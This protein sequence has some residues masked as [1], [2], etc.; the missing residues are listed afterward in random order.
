MGADSVI[1]LN[2][3]PL[4]IITF[5]LTEIC[6]TFDTVSSL[7]NNICRST[8]KQITGKIQELLRYF[9][10]AINEPL[11]EPIPPLRVSA[12]G[13]IDLTYYM[14]TINLTYYYPHGLQILPP[15]AIQP[16]C[17]FLFHCHYRQKKKYEP[18]RTKR[19]LF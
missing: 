6:D 4:G 10:K 2:K 19:K 11:H 1:Y 7:E 18:L 9:S 14:D 12:N 16:F 3:I 8:N 13:T 15:S 5:S 17:L